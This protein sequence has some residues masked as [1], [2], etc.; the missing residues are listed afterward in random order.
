MTTMLG[1]TNMRREGSAETFLHQIAERSG[2][3]WDEADPTLS[4]GKVQHWHL[5]DTLLF[6]DH[7]R[8]HSLSP[9]YAQDAENPALRDMLIF[10]TRKPVV[11]GHVSF[12]FDSL[13]EHQELPLNVSMIDEKAGDF[14]ERHPMLHPTSMLPIDRSVEAFV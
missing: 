3:K 5:L 9:V 1:H 11:E 10:F 8:K 12:E 7:E 14:D 13:R 4:L 2:I 6:V